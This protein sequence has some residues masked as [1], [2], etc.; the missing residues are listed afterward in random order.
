[1]VNP[2]SWATAK[3][4]EFE[5]FKISDGKG[6]GNTSEIM[7]KT[8]ETNNPNVHTVVNSETGRKL[9]F[10]AMDM[11]GLTRAVSDLGL[12]KMASKFQQK[13][14]EKK[15]SE[16]LKDLSESIRALTDFARGN[17]A[18]EPWVNKLV[19]PDL[20]MQRW[21]MDQLP[22]QMFYDCVKN[23]SSDEIYSKDDAEIEVENYNETACK[24]GDCKNSQN[25]IMKETIKQE[26][27]FQVEN[28]QIIIIDFPFF[29][30]KSECWLWQNKICE[31]IWLLWTTKLA[32]L[33]R[34]WLAWKLAAGILH[35][36]A[37]S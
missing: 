8:N 23:D 7:H 19:K 30:A 33:F 2:E 20:S 21:F 13:Q 26:D 36:T 37:R 17:F 5:K 32:S 34:S 4:K 31:T 12:D 9:E 29:C 25:K 1:M 35:A 14:W 28:D 27:R 24:D 15:V 18:R 6:G 3:L 11:G 16:G 10:E 22:K